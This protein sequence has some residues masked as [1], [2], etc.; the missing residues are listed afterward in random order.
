MEIRMGIG[1]LN[2]ELE[3][4]IFF[5]F[6]VNMIVEFKYLNWDNFRSWTGK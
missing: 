4:I 6:K 3:T 1:Y 5:D 2:G